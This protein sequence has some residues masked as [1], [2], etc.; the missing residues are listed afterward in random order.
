MMYNLENGMPASYKHSCSAERQGQVMTAEELHDFAVEVLAAE[1]AETGAEVVKLEKARG[2]EADFRFTNTGKKPQFMS[3]GSKRPINVLVVCRDEPDSDISDIDTTWLVEEYL[4][5]GAIPRVTIAMAWCM[6]DENGHTAICGGDFCFKYHS[7]SVLPDQQSEELEDVLSPA[8]LAVKFEEAWEEYDATIVAPYLDKDF[9]YGSHWV[10]DE[11]PCR[12]E[13]LDYL[14][15][16]LASWKSDG[17]MEGISLTRNHQN[18][19]VALMFER[20]RTMLEL[21]TENG[22]ITSA[23]MNIYDSKYRPFNPEDELF[24]NHGD[25]ID[26]IMPVQ[27][28]FS[29]RL[30]GVVNKAKPWR[31]AYTEVTTD[32]MYETKTDVFSLM[33]G[34]E[35]IRML[36]TVAASKKSQENVLLSAYPFGKGVPVS[37]RINKVMEWDNQTEATV[38]GS[39]GKFEFAFFPIDYY[40]NKNLYEVGETVTIDL[41]ALGMKVEEAQRGFMFEGQQAIDWLAKIGKEASYDK[42]GNVEPVKFSTEN[43]VAFLNIDSKCPDE[44]EFQSPADGIEATTFLGVDF[45]KTNV[46]I[47]RR[48]TDDGHLQIS[49]PLYFRQEFFPD[50][51]KSDPLRGW[52]WMTGSVSG[53]HEEN[54]ERSER[55]RHMGKIAAE[56]EEYMDECDLDSSDDLMC[57]M[58]MLPSLTIRDGYKLGAFLKGDSHGWYMQAYCYKADAD[59]RRMTEIKG[60][61]DDSVRIEG[62]IDHESASKVPAALTYMEVPFTEE[63]IMQAWLLNS[64]TYFMPMGWHANY[65]QRYFIFD[66]LRIDDLFSHSDGD[67]Q[68]TNILKE[69]RMKVSDQVKDL[70]VESLFPTV[71]INGDKAMLEYTYWNDWSGMNKV[72]LPVKKVGNS[73]EFGEPEVKNILKY[74]CSLMF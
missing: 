52:L 38:F 19:K 27:A 28:F 7:V 40:C 66:K 58:D 62:R 54:F 23:F 30:Q 24:M 5:T 4:R 69:E 12:K 15:G 44:A 31:M 13:F 53:G 51:K 1:Y 35:D 45:F 32:D 67:G 18:G 64:L 71:A 22:R 43:L 59:A 41:A 37:V 11:L 73:V 63:G 29:E 10:F 42:E 55:P 70:D 72:K 26:C 68:L 39:V 61:Y 14:E 47:C 8:E 65:G 20:S 49:I 34:E 48:D 6:D 56:F 21:E 2:C 33:Y 36:V 60:D 17:Y 25:H 50:V 16:K 46:T 9:H 57:V 3:S 74:R